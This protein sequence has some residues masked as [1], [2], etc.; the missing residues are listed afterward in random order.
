MKSDSAVAKKLERITK[1]SE[2]LSLMEESHKTKE[3]LKTPIKPKQRKKY[4]T[5]EYDWEEPVRTFFYKIP[6]ECKSFT[7]KFF[8]PKGIEIK[9]RVLKVDTELGYKWNVDPP[10][11][12]QFLKEG[13]RVTWEGKNL[14]AFE[15]YKFDW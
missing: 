13:T 15:A 2:I 8:I 1:V 12:I 6:T 4:I 10:A 5:L 7:Y 9:N 3:W 14:K 11:R